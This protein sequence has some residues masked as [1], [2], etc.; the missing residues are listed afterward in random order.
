MAKR[1]SSSNDLM[2]CIKKRKW[3]RIEYHL[4]ETNF[5]E[6]DN[7]FVLHE[8]CGD[9]TAPVEVVSSV[10]NALVGDNDKNT[11]ISV[12]VEAEFDR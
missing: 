5:A 6:R 3:D 2:Q 1:S 12:A 10:Y 9:P 8:V 4:N 11:P 7:A